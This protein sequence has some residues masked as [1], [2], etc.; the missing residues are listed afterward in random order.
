MYVLFDE[1]LPRLVRVL[2]ENTNSQKISYKK[3]KYIQ[4]YVKQL[5]SSVLRL[6]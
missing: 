1:V 6:F 2:K 5:R 4:N 3:R